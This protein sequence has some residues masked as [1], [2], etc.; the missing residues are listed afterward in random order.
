MTTMLTVW[1]IVVGS[2]MFCLCQYSSTPG[3]PSRPPAV[4]P[5]DSQIPR[6]SQRPT[7]LMFAH[8][9]CPCTRASIGELALILAHC[10][11]R[12]D[13][14]VLF[15]Q[16]SDAAEEWSK[17]DLWASAE[18]IPGVQVTSDED[19]LEAARFQAHTSGQA[20]LYAAN[21]RLLFNGGITPARGHSGDNAGRIAI[22]SILSDGTATA[23][24]AF[25]FGCPIADP[26]DCRVIEEQGSCQQ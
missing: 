22:E 2:G 6:F 18:S 21:G 20:L 10:P 15:F 26:R 3:K 12:V 4:W 14:R 13:A 19:G 23:S 17:T 8:P 16:P 9:R 11:D 1:L 7:L 24:W 25:T 5:A